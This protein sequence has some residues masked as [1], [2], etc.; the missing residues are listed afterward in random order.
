MSLLRN[1]RSS[2]DST[3]ITVLLERWSAG[4]REAAAR[5]MPH[6]YPELRRIA[7]RLWHGERRDHTLQPTA[8]VHEAYLDLVETRG[9]RWRNRS[10][11]LG[12]A[13]HLMRRI[14]VLHSRR[15]DALKRGGRATRIRLKEA[16]TLGVVRAPDL[17]DLDW[18][19]DDLA[20]HDRQK[21]QIVELRIFG[22]LTIW[23]TAEV[24][25]VSASTVNRQWR[26]AIAWLN[27][28]LHPEDLEHDSRLD[29]DR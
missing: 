6:V 10:E 12:F 26:R 8:L 9:V 21:A 14:L 23:E 25:G 3:S 17:I 22:G 13:A 5:V 28:A 4:D 24:L 11:F 7:R 1:R 20:G 19:L 2:A 15:H 16:K 27:D 18:A 29:Q